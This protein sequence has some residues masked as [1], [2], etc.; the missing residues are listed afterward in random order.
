MR[1]DKDERVE[2]KDTERQKRDEEEDEKRKDEK[3]REE[4][5]EGRKLKGR[6]K[7]PPIP[8]TTGGKTGK[9][10][11]KGPEGNGRKE[12]RERTTTERKKKLMSNRRAHKKRRHDKRRQGNLHGQRNKNQRGMWET[13]N[14][15]LPRRR[16]A[17]GGVTSGR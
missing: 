4:E 3:F 15:L 1:R 17:N 10:T 5:E 7:A 12:G 2:R 13:R 16:P 8:P 9:R 14:N 11:R 6:I